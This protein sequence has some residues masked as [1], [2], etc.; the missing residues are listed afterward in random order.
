MRYLYDFAKRPVGH[1]ILEQIN[2]AAARLYEKMEPLVAE[3]QPISD[4]YRRLLADTQ[5]QLTGSLQMFSYILAWS[6]QDVN[7]PLKDVT[8]IEVGGGLGMMALLAKEVGI[9]TV[10]H[11]DIYEAACVDAKIVAEGIGVPADHY[12]VGD[13]D[14]LI[15]YTKDNG[16]EIDSVGSYDVIEHIYDIDEYL[17]DLV[18]LPGKNL[19]IAMASGA[20][21]YKPGYRNWITPFQIQCELEGRESEE[22]AEYERDTLRPYV[23]IRQ[24]M[25]EAVE[26]EIAAADVKKLV[27]CTR[28][29]RHEDI[30]KTARRFVETGKMPPVLEHPTNTCDPYTGNW[31]EHLMNPDDLI[32]VMRKAGFDA[33][34]ISGYFNGRS[35]VLAKRTA[36]KVVNIGM[37]LFN[38][39]GIRFAPYYMI[40]GRLERA[41]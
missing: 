6:L 15:R 41:S 12:V 13:I 29:M 1:E 38:K 39:P 5:A 22:T 7:K 18:H 27:K 19:T 21:M 10:I 37:R 3:E 25:I 11:N 31:Q 35:P 33:D 32:A 28:G 40:N 30:E 20:N 23:A 9:G 8:V 14:E 34:W 16:L 26:P 4:L 2:A 24:E 36:A 17:A